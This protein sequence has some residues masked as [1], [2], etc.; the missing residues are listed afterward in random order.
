MGSKYKNSWGSWSPFGIYGIY[1]FAGLFFGI[2]EL[3]R[4]IIPSDIV[5]CD[6]VKLRK[7]DSIVQICNETA[8][9]IGALYAYVWI[10][11]FGWG[12]AF[13]LLPICFTIA[14]GLWYSI[15]PRDEAQLSTRMLFAKNDSL[16][17]KTS[18]IIYSVYHSISL[19]VKLVLTNRALFWLI[20]SY[21]LPLVMHRYLEN[22]LIPFFSKSNL[23]NSDYQTILIGGSNFGELMG[24]VTVLLLAK[25]VKTP[26]PFLRLDVFLQ[27][28][29]WIL[30]FWPVDSFVSPLFAAWG[31]APIMFLISY[32]WCAGDV[33]LVAYIQSRLG[34]LENIDQYTNPLGAVMSFLYILMLITFY[35]LNLGMSAVRD[36]YVN[37]KKSFQELYILIGGVFMTLCGVI[38]LIGTFI[39]VGAFAWN[40]NPDAAPF[41]NSISINGETIEPAVKNSKSTSDNTTDENDFLH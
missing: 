26:I 34:N 36:N 4:R 13:T 6:Q 19:G 18:T 10:G 7:V 31:L 16:R 2:I 37:N 41:D 23:K 25:K 40:P 39:P 17:K 38:T 22:T 27:L 33:S 15:V 11:Y 14:C 3:I 29:I 21:V 32:G 20:P 9:T 30:P 28:L 1:A 35:C 5:G 24:A 12:Y 8:G